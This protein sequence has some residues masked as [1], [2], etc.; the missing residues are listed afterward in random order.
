LA[1]KQAVRCNRRIAIEMRKM[2]G[3]CSSAARHGLRL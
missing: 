2:R 1:V 3:R